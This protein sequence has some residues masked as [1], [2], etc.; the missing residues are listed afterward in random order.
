MNENKL[1]NLL[2]EISKETGGEL[3]TS[4][5]SAPLVSSTIYDIAKEAYNLHVKVTKAADASALNKNISIDFNWDDTSFEDFKIE[6]GKSL[7]GFLSPKVKY[8]VSGD[9]NQEVVQFLISTLKSE[10]LTG[11]RLF[12]IECQD[13]VLSIRFKTLYLES[14]RSMLSIL[15]NLIKKY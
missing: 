8:K 3:K 13:R 6:I 9:E 15:L 14:L 11:V 5:D 4:S 12:K 2:G 1:V 7:F 10:H